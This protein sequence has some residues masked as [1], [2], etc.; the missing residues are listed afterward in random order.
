MKY[1]SL[2]P[3]LNFLRSVNIIY[4]KPKKTNILVF[5]RVGSTDLIPYFR[6]LQYEILDVRGE[7]INGY[8]LLISLIKYFHKIT[9]ER[10][11]DEFIKKSNPSCVITF[12]DNTEY[13]YKLKQYN[14]DIFF[15]SIQNGWRDNVLFEIFSKS[16]LYKNNLQSDYLFC[17]GE[18]VG[19]IYGSFIKTKV[20]P[21]GSFKSN[22]KPIKKSNKSKITSVLFIS[23]YRVPV[24]SST[25]PCMPIGERNV[26]WDQFYNSEFQLLP[27]LSDFCL[28]NNLILKICGGSESENEKEFFQRVL[29]KRNYEYKERLNTYSSYTEIDNAE[30]IVFIDSTLGY[31]A[32][33][34]GLKTAAFSIRGNDLDTD[35]RDFGFHANLPKKGPFWTN[36]LNYS[37]VDRIFKFLLPLSNEEWI[38]TSSSISNKLMSYNN[39]NTIFANI[40]NQITKE[41]VQK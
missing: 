9:F 4:K 27:L 11:V 15:I 13:F 38:N 6:G 33:G 1:S 36:E 35:D 7:T 28:D 25:G 24:Q 19:V 40:L 31:E 30:I 2:V 17:F 41:Y 29:K 22:N 12:I 5:D 18:A 37:E 39:N 34:R 26:P 16:K 8:V 10:Y 14:P 20:V 3:A 32:L 21:I 23:Q